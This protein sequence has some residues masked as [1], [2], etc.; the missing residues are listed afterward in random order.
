MVLVQPNDP[1]SPAG[2]N[3]TLP[4]AYGPSAER[5]RKRSSL[6]RT[7]TAKTDVRGEDP[8]FIARRLNWLTAERWR[9]EPRPKANGKSHPGCRPLNAMLR[10]GAS[11]QP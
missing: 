6:A 1:P 2:G 7:A 4:A 5:R 9:D 8:Q 10:D 3:P 11:W